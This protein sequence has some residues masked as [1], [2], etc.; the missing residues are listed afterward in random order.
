[1]QMTDDIFFLRAPSLHAPSSLASS[2]TPKPGTDYTS[3][4]SVPCNVHSD[5]ALQKAFVG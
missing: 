1:M 3:P 5:C 4:S 2:R